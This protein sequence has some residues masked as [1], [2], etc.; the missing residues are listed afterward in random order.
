MRGESVAIGLV[1]PK[2]DDGVL[3]SPGEY[4]R[5]LLEYGDMWSDVAEVMT[6]QQYAEWFRGNR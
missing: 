6:T 1:V 5:W 4:E 3:L 2:H